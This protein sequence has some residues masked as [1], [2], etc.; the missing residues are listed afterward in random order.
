MAFTT[1]DN[2]ELYFQVKTYTGNGGT[3]AITLDGSED[4]SPNFVWIKERNLTSSH[5]LTDTVRGN[6]IKIK[7]DESDAEETNTN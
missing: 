2:P 5:A 3:L 6:T 7:T 4:M 1:I